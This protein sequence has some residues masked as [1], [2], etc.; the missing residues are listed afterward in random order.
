[1]CVCVRARDVSRGRGGGG[2]LLVL[3]ILRYASLALGIG[4]CQSLPSILALCVACCLV[5]AR[6]AACRL[7]SDLRS[8]AGR[9]SSALSVG[10]RSPC[11]YLTF[12][13]GNAWLCN[14]LCLVSDSSTHQRRRSHS[15]CPIRFFDLAWTE[16]RHTCRDTVAASARRRGTKIWP[17]TPPSCGEYPEHPSLRCTAFFCGYCRCMRCHALDKCPCVHTAFIPGLHTRM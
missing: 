12:T 10:T 1:M 6:C 3:C 9:G 11:R 4:C 5:H 14:G 7:L 15:R 17:I 2:G 8:S 16:V 13:R